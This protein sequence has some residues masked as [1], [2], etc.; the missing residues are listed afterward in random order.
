M[1]FNEMD[2]LLF[3]RFF[4][5]KTDSKFILNMIQINFNKKVDKANEE[6]VKNTLYD[7]IHII[8]NYLLYQTNRKL[9]IN[10]KFSVSINNEI[11][12]QLLVSYDSFYNDCLLKNVFNKS[13][14]NYF[15]LNNTTNKET[16]L[17]TD[18]NKTEYFLH[19][20]LNY[21]YYIIFVHNNKDYKTQH[22]LIPIIFNSN[23]NKKDFSSLFSNEN[24][25][26]KYNLS[27]KYRKNFINRLV[28]FFIRY[29]KKFPFVIKSLNQACLEILIHILVE[30]YSINNISDM[31]KFL[32]LFKL[33]VEIVF[34]TLLLFNEKNIKIEKY[35]KFTNDLLC[36]FLTKS[37]KNIL[38]IIKSFNIKGIDEKKCLNIF[39][40][41]YTKNKI[42]NNGK[43]IKNL[44]LFF[45][46][47]ILNCIHIKNKIL[48]LFMIKSLEEISLSYS[49]DSDLN[50]IY[51]FQSFSSEFLRK[52]GIV[53][54]LDEFKFNYIRNKTKNNNW[55]TYIGK[56]M[57][58]YL[59]LIGNNCQ[60]ILNKSFGHVFNCFDKSF[61]YIFDV[62][63]LLTTESQFYYMNIENK[64]LQ[65]YRKNIFNYI[66]NLFTYL[67]KNKLSKE[68]F[69]YYFKPN[70]F[71]LKKS[72]IHKISY[73]NETSS[74]KIEISKK[75][76]F[77]NLCNYLSSEE[78]QTKVLNSIQNI[79]TGIPPFNSLPTQCALLEAYLDELNEANIANNNIKEKVIEL[80]KD[81]I[82]EK[83]DE[84]EL[85]KYLDK[86]CLNSIKYKE[87]IIYIVL[88]NLGKE[89]ND[90]EELTLISNPTK[91]L[92]LIIKI[93]STESID[94]NNDILI[95]CLQC[96]YSLHSI[97]KLFFD[98]EDEIKYI[99]LLNEIKGKYNIENDLQSDLKEKIN[100]LNNELLTNVKKND[101]IKKE[102]SNNINNNL[103]EEDKKI[104]ELINN[105]KKVEMK[106]DKFELSFMLKKLYNELDTSPNV[107]KARKISI[108]VIQLVINYLNNLL[109]TKCFDDAFMTQNVLKVY[110]NLFLSIKSDE[111]LRKSYLKIISEFL[112]SLLGKKNFISEKDKSTKIEASAKIFELFMKI[113]KKLK[114]K[115][116]LIGKDILK[117]LFEVF[118]NE[119]KGIYKLT[120]Y[121]IVSCISMCAY[122]VEYCHEEIM[123]YI[124]II[125][126]TGINF[127]KS[128]KSSTI[129]QQRASS[130]LL[131][132]V[133][134]VLNDQELDSYSKEIFDACNIA[135]NYS[136][137]N[138]VLFY[139]DKCLNYYS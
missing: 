115:S 65:N 114:Y 58:D 105:C 48:T 25:S 131:Y 40:D 136:N 28:H 45:I 91:I 53:L 118:E 80:P 14:Y 71:W 139:V 109:I 124:S 67:D 76:N 38:F 111:T 95:N 27:D 98:Y 11:Y 133:L 86:I 117:I 102:N 24:N 129:E 77:L 126:R 34:R 75:L 113:I 73:I 12:S 81:L 36:C 13:P 10:K 15:L 8:K 116:Y 120:P 79:F 6:K 30:Y 72:I 4:S 31:N 100:E 3:Q 137:D 78:Y 44:F 87:K 55:C 83:E 47:I 17:L 33:N 112:Y 43:S 134:D 35:K 18:K 103:G 42:K 92:Y 138:A 96:V 49:Y 41:M 57:N 128:S 5:S 9:A 2:I 22:N 101:N 84:E 122:L 74:I 90:K 63:N 32:F 107:N 50:N 66:S 94:E 89:T 69:K 29:H 119:K 110:R 1:S 135:R 88:E 93:L 85:K 56:K 46:E 127:L 39:F 62:L 16:Y 123:L 108:D 132:K 23:N 19:C 99:S 7:L 37:S 64:E 61:I 52:F 106:K 121:S 104:V 54:N 20:I 26:S 68:I 82:L 125:I 70:C 130:F 59:Y 21:S 60:M 51:I 97:G